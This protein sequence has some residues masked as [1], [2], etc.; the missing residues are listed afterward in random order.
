MLRW[1]LLIFTAISLVGSSLTSW[2]AAGVIG[3]ASCCCPVKSK[4]KCHDHDGKP[5]SSPTLKKCGGEAKLVAPV[6]VHAVAATTIGLDSEQ[7]V[8]AISTSSL[9]ATPEDHPIEPETP[10]F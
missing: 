5:D 8:T 7:V 4:C 2:A 6:I 10:P 3:D 1:L 9:Q